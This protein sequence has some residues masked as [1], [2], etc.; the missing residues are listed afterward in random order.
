MAEETVKMQLCT[1]VVDVV[2]SKVEKFKAQGYV[3]LKDGKRL[4]YV[5]PPEP[6]TPDVGC[7]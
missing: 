7:C 3:E 2:K 4:P 6:K 5:K 1:A